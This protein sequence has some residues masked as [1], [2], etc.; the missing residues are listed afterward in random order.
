MVI[1]ESAIRGVYVVVWG[2]VSGGGGDGGDGGHL[3]GGE[4]REGCERK[5]G[6]E[7]VLWGSVKLKD[8]AVIECKVGRH[9]AENL[10]IPNY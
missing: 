1:Y 6:E 7:R 3:G 10:C 4:G 9:C 5:R 8:Q 2:G